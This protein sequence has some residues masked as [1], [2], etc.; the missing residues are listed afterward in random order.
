MAVTAPITPPTIYATNPKI[1]YLSM[2]L[3]SMLFFS[4]RLV[5]HFSRY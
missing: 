1:A 3:G 2:I 4:L 5:C